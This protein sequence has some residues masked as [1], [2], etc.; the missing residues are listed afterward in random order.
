[1]KHVKKITVAPADPMTDF[2]SDIFRAMQ[3]LQYS[4]KNATG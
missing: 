4:K 2:M 1:M 3:D